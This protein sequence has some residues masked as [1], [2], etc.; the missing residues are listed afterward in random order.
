MADGGGSG[1]VAAPAG[2]PGRGASDQQHQNVSPWHRSRD[3]RVVLLLFVA[4]WVVYLLTATYDSYQV[5]DNRAVATSAWSLGAR[6]TLELPAEWEGSIDWETPGTDGRLFT[7]RFPGAILLAAPA[8]AA[9]GLLGLADQPSHPYFLTYGPAGVTAA[10]IAALVVA[11]LY[12]VFRR[13][14]ERRTALGA[15]SLFAFGTASWSVTADAMWT[16]GT[17]SLGLA[18]GMLALASGREA[19]AGSAYA[20]SILARP[21]TAVVAAV[22]GIWRGV[23]LR[24]LR[25]VVVIGLTSSLGLLAVSIYSRL[26]FGTWLPIAGYDPSKVGAVV[27]SGSLEFAE[28]FLFTL[29][30]PTRGVLRFTPILVMLLPLLHRGW[31]TAPSWVRSSAVAGVVYLVVQLRSNVWHGGAD[32]F[33]SRLTIE[34]LVLAA[35]LLLCTWQAAIRPTRLLRW[36]FTVLAVLSIVIHAV[37]ATYLSVSPS[38]RERHAANREALCETEPAPPECADLVFD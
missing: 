30:H 16:H 31:R 5:N 1:H 29:G 26:L 13:L 15:A 2:R 19:W 23:Q 18:G 32:F 14:V 11:V 34:T 10:T 33:G 28:R 8:Y 25:P 36:C 12:G 22:I 27:T 20:A 9:A 7:D 24:T 38:G 17:T 4:T 3:G 6:G 37:G 35:P 21:Q